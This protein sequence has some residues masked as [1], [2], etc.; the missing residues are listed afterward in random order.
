MK[1][2][3][4]LLDSTAAF[5]AIGHRDHLT[6]DNAAAI[7]RVCRGLWRDSLLLATA[8]KLASIHFVQGCSSLTEHMEQADL[9]DVTLA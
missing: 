4:L 9:R 1:S 7:L 2:I 6:M 3:Q 8:I 5:L